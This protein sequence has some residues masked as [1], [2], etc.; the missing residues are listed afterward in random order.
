[1]MKYF[2]GNLPNRRAGVSYALGRNQP[3]CI[4]FVKW[5]YLTLVDPSKVLPSL[6]AGVTP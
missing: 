6:H 3:C 2:E 4:K 5:F 1:M